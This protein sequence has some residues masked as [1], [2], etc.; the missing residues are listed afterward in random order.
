VVAG[1]SGQVYQHIDVVV[2]DQRR[3]LGIVQADDVPPTG[4]VCAYPV[5]GRVRF[6]RIGIAVDFERAIAVIEQRLEEEG[7]RVIAEIR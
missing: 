7:Y 6:E 3:G 1:V 5:S 2:L 4:C